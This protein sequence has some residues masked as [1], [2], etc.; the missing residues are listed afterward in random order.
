MAGKFRPAPLRRILL[1]KFVG[2]ILSSGSER[3]CGRRPG[4]QMG[5]VSARLIATT[6]RRNP[7]DVQALV[8]GGGRRHRR[9][10]NAPIAGAVFVLEEL[11]RHFETRDAITVFA[12]STAIWSRGCCS[13]MPHPHVALSGQVTATTGPLPY[14]AAATWPLYLRLVPGGFRSRALQPTDHACLAGRIC[15]RQ[16]ARRSQ[17]CI[18][19]AIVGL[20]GWLPLDWRWQQPAQIALA[21]AAVAGGIPLASPFYSV[22]G[23][24]PTPHASLRVVRSSSCA[25]RFDRLFLAGLFDAAFRPCHRATAFA[26]VG[27]AAFFTGVVGAPVTGIVLVIEMT[28]P[29]PRSC[30]CWSPACGDADRRPAD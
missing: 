21:C 29:L 24:C 12:S 27:M 2:G 28:A 20:I 18:V 9:R 13:S 22:S 17:G 25:R 19:G 6:F 23:R 15:A 8:A 14:A 26:V 11:F 30:R 10:V 4:V 16:L 1:I 5:A 3:R 7:P